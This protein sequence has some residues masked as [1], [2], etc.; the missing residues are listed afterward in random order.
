MYPGYPSRHNNRLYP[1]QNF[2]NDD[3]AENR[4]T[5]KHDEIFNNRINFKEEESFKNYYKPSYP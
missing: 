1:N 4:I 3:D 5:S 2:L